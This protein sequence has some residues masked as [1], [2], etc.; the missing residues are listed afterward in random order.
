[1]KFPITFFYPGKYSI[2]HWIF[3]WWSRSEG[4]TFPSE[5]YHVYG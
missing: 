5:L 3:Q 2:L 4:R 1:M